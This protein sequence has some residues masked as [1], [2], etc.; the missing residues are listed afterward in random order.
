LGR[1]GGGGVPTGRTERLMVYKQV[2]RHMLHFSLLYYQTAKN[3]IYTYSIRTSKHSQRHDLGLAYISSGTI[4]K[5]GTRKAEK[6]K[7]PITKTS[8]QRGHLEQKMLASFGGRKLRRASAKSLAIYQL[9]VH[10][11]LLE[12]SHFL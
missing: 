5:I 3:P 8:L 2:Q 6:L 9:L 7:N 11:A 4:L 12:I 1:V 10:I